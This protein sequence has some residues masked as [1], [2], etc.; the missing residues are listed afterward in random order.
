MK[1][2]P[3]EIGDLE[4]ALDA[5]QEILGLDVTMNYMPLMEILKGAR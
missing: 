3:A 1:N 4:L 5:N 2:R